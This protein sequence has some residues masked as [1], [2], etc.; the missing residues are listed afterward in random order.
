MLT[1]I[2][3]LYS[4]L[5]AKIGLREQFFV[6]TTLNTREQVLFFNM[7][8]IDQRHCL[9][10][11]QT[12]VSLLNQEQRPV[13][14]ALLI[15][16]ALL[17]DTGKRAGDLKLRDRIVVVLVRLLNQSLFDRLAR[18]AGTPYYVAANHAAIGAELC[19]LA[20]CEEDLVHLVA[21]HQASIPFDAAGV[22]AELLMKADQLN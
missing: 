16:A 3:Q 1:R 17:H 14:K 2:K 10:V 6:V 7:D 11:A 19:R 20:R 18:Q 22:E 5:T 12:C 13:N 8:I 21:N 9:D 15:K 4:A